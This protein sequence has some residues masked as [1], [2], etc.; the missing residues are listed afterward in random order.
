MKMRH[1]AMGCAALFTATLAQAAPPSLNIYYVDVEGGQAT[2][3][4]APSGQTVLVDTGFP[5]ARD[6]GRILEA[7]KAAG[8]SKI[9]YLLI[10]H[11]HLDHVGGYPDLAKLLPI[12]HYVDHGTT[13]QPEQHGESKSA[14]DAATLTHPHMIA[15]PGDKLP[16]AGIDWTIVS[17]AGKVLTTSMAGNPGAGAANPYCATFK[18]KDITIDLENQQSVGSVI[19]YGKF[20]TVDLGD[21]LWNLEAELVCPVN[22]IG[23][24]DVFTVS[25]HGYGWSGAPALIYALHPRVAIMDNGNQKGAQV[26]IF[27]TLESSPGLENLWQLHWSVNGLIEHNTPGVFIANLE[28]PDVT[29]ATILHPPAPPPPATRP[30]PIGNEDHTPAYWIE[31]SAQ[32]DGTFTVTNSRNG[33]SKTYKRRE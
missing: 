31:V 13:V 30:P 23:T 2:L 22:R 7:A 17:S 8:V 16:I 25:H 28:S 32:A 24:I 21:L 10:T 14:Y 18:P 9:D 4:V 33:F 5:G 12:E 11:Y 26:E 15:K 20:R 6:A 29:A 1:G 27:Q 19:R 3:F